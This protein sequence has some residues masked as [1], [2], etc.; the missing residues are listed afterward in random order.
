MVEA[1]RHDA[2]Q[3]GESY[4]AYMGRCSRKLAPHFLDWLAAPED[5]DWLDIGCG[6]GALSAAILAQ[7]KP[8]SL[9]AIPKLSLRRYR[10][11]LPTSARCSGSAMPRRSKWKRTAETSSYRPW[12]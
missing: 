2:W 10:Q 3:A 1:S 7:Y 9:L 8:T 11:T 12:C 4:D 6:T 5:R